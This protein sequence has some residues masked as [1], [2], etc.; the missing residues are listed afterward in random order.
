MSTSAQIILIGLALLLSPATLVVTLFLRLYTFLAIP[1][2]APVIGLVT[3]DRKLDISR[4]LQLF[5]QLALA[6]SGARVVAITP[7][8]HPHINSIINQIDGLILSGGEDLDEALHHNST[9]KFVDTNQVRDQLELELLELANQR[10]IPYLC[11]CRGAQLMSIKEN[12]RIS[13]HKHDS[14][15][16]APHTS[17][18]FNFKMH[19]IDLKT[20]SRI[21]RIFQAEKITVNS[22]HHISIDDAGNAVATAHHDDIIETVEKPGDNFALGV[23][24]HP[25]LM[26]PFDQ[27]QQRLFDAFVESVSQ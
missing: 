19:S 18:L 10:S 16:I 24:W 4:F 27:S 6:R 13:S 15:K 8:H 25:E 23:Q 11:V 17:S 3:T 1:K 7:H 20:N 26:A 12:G 9:A 2:N 14:P 5:F 21:A 22:F